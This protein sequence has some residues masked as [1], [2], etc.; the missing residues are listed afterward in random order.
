MR[1]RTVLP[2]GFVAGAFESRADSTKVE[3]YFRVNGGPEPVL[4]PLPEYMMRRIFRLGQAFGLVQLK[5]LEAGTH[6][7]IGSADIPQLVENLKRLNKLVNDPGT[8]KYSKALLKVLAP[9]GQ[10]LNRHVAIFT[11][12]KFA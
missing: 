8:L 5:Y 1:K 7:V 6:L 3:A 12:P 11:G 9:D 2:P 4:I 10:P